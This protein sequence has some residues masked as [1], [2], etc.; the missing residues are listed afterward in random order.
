M[1]FPQT[2]SYNKYNL[3]AQTNEKQAKEILI[4]RQNTLRESLRKG[5]SLPWGKPVGGG[6]NRITRSVLGESIIS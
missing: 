1:L 3:N 6:C 2:L 5:Q 4:R